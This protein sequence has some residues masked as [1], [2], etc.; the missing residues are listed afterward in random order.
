MNLLIQK[1]KEEF[2]CESYVGTD[3]KSE[4]NLLASK[5]RDGFKFELNSVGK[6]RFPLN[7]NLSWNKLNPDIN[8]TER[9]LKMICGIN[10]IEEYPTIVSIAVTACI[11]PVS[12]TEWLRGGCT[13]NE[14]K[15]IKKL[16]Q[17]VMPLMH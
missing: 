2:F 11:I 5:W 9:F 8:S 10:N 7:E 16:H 14:L 15:Q 6:K 3:V 17:K 12:N 1:Y 13:L 4:V